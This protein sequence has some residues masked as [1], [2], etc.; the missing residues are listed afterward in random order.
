MSS[1]L[2]VCS[3]LFVVL[4]PL[5]LYIYDDFYNPNKGDDDFPW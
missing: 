3:I 4:C 5:A 2:M 1:F